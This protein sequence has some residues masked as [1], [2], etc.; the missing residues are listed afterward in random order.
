MADNFNSTIG[1]AYLGG[2][3]IP[4]EV[5]QEIIQTMPESSVLLTRAKRVPNWSIKPQPPSTAL[6]FTKLDI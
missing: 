1:R 5:S 6:P 4:D 3:L 2:A